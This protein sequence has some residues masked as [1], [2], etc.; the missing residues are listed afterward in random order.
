M[1]VWIPVPSASIVGRYEKCTVFNWLLQ[2]N[3]KLCINLTHD[4]THQDMAIAPGPALK[5]AAIV[6]K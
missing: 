1:L 5:P 4:P 3:Q 2:R 6:N